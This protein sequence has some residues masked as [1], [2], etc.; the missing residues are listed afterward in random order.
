MRRYFNYI[1]HAA[2]VFT[3]FYFNAPLKLNAQDYDSTTKVESRKKLIARGKYLTTIAACGSCHA[4][5]PAR[6]TSPLSGGL[7]LKD[8]FGKVRAANITSDKKSGIGDWSK[9][10]IQNAIRASIGKNGEYLSIESHQAYRWMSDDDV[11]AI[12]SYLLSTKPLSSEIEK[13][14]IN[15]FTAKKWGVFSQHEQVKGFVPGISQNSGG[16]YGMYLVGS[17]ANCSRCHSPAENSLESSSFLA[18]SKGKRFLSDAFFDLKEYPIAPS[19]RNSEGALYAWTD[20]DIISF[21]TKGRGIAPERSSKHCPTP[22]YASL[23]E[24]DKKSII[25]Y[26]RSLE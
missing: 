16:Y 24:S 9:D 22:Y 2:L 23:N 20:K 6:P 14:S 13:R 11:Y 21:I 5:D 8:S 1:V 4:H 17:I 3:L 10:E 7:L 19:I 12:S 25:K 15:S 26:L 18:G